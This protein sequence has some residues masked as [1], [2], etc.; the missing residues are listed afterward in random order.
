VKEMDEESEATRQ[1]IKDEFYKQLKT[2]GVCWAT[3][4][5][6]SY[7]LLIIEELAERAIILS[8]AETLS[9]SL[10]HR[11]ALVTGVPQMHYSMFLDIKYLTG[12]RIEIA[13]AYIGD[14][15]ISENVAERNFFCRIARARAKNS[16][17]Q[18]FESFIAGDV[19]P[20]NWGL[21]VTD[22]RFKLINNGV[23]HGDFL[24]FPSDYP[25]K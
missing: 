1:E 14:I 18:L 17:K 25:G 23:D 22:L 12:E 4:P 11:T 13:K 7:E 2:N 19:I 24:A 20:D 10:N 3:R 16:P 6:P 15:T 21:N 8:G 5:S 9:V